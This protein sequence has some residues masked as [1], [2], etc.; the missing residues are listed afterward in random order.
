VRKL[1]RVAAI[2]YVSYLVLTLLVIT[3]ALNFLPHKYLKDTYNREL[4]TRWVLLNPFKL[5]LDI[6]GAQL[7]DPGGERFLAFNDASVNLSLESLWRSSWV[8][9]AVTLRGLYLAIT[10]LS[11]ERYNFSDLLSAAASEEPPETTA[12]PLPAVTVHTVELQSEAIVLTDQA[13]KKPY[14][15]RWNGLHIKVNEISTLIEAGSPFNVAVE[16]EGGG[17]LQWEGEFSIPKGHS[18]GKLQ[19]SDLDLHQVWLF[20]EEWLALRLTKGRLLVEGQYEVDWKDELSYR[21]SNGHIAL[22]QIDIVPQSPAQLPDTAV[23]LKTLDIS[24]IALDSGTRKVTIDAVAIDE[25][26]VSTWREGTNVSLQQLF[27]VNLPGDQ[28]AA[29]DD[30]APSWSLELHKAQ[31]HNGKLHWRSEFTDPQQLHAAPIEASLEHLAWPLSGDTRLALSAAVNEQV[32]LTVNSTLALDA[33]NG[34][35]EYALLGLPLAWF[36]PNLPKPLK[37]TI[38]GGEVEIKGQLALADY[39]PT[40][41]ALDGKIRKFSARREAEETELTGFDLVRIDNLAVDM[42]RHSLVLKKLTIDTYTGRLHIQKD[43]SINAANIWKRE[44]GDEAQKIAAELTEDKP[45]T[46]SIPTIS[47]SDSAIDFS[48][49]SL[50]IQFRTVIGDI[51]GEVLNLGSD[52]S[53]AASVDLDGAVDGYA[54]VTL[55]GKVIPLAKPTDLDLTLV[56]DGV[57]MALLSPYSSTYAGYVIDQGLLDLN[58]HYTLKNNQ[59]QGDNALRIEK[60]KLGEKVESS[61]ALDLPLELAL[62]ILTDANGVIDVA[63]PVKGDVNKPEFEIG[64]LLAKA[65]VNLLTKAVTAPFKLLAGLVASEDDLQRITFTSGS[66][67]LSDKNK[68][69]LNELAAALGQRPRLSLVITGRLNTKADR[70][71]LQRNALRAQLLEEGLSSEEIKAMGPDWEEAITERFE[72]LPA[73]D[74]DAEPPS[75]R[76]QYKQVWHSIVIPDAQLTELMALRATAVKR[77]L[78][79]EA[80]LAPE[81]AVIGQADLNDK[82][83]AFSGVELSIG[84]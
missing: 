10:R 84:N 2:I 35:V 29:K 19:L 22:S 14:I 59:L 78:A 26:A 51:E 16:A 49:D 17:K 31:L 18:A 58:L 71:R 38:T 42:T 34:S 41:I 52:T 36:N 11:D 68:E 13:R 44:V 32:K 28:A 73:A 74:T 69:K 83:N 5:S 4:K 20:A 62:A 43:G 61:K 60:L 37:A 9:D 65:F 77:Y 63:V 56:F 82:K 67:S 70:E 72:E 25:L 64:S 79:T 81:R 55:K 45:W 48:D 6:Q 24:N 33:G 46:F 66:A 54:P 12:E 75:V 1:L 21:L 30:D 15:S 57:D 50:P 47:I 39:S 80:G 7:N 3:P 40:T 8:L 76:E 23:G 53:H 27:A